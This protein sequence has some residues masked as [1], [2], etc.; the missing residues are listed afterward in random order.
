[1]EEETLYTGFQR[2]IIGFHSYAIYVGKFIFP[3]IMS[4]LYPYPS[5]I[6]PELYVSALLL[7]VSIIGIV[8]AF[9]RGMTQ[10]V[11]GWAFFFVNFIFV[12]QIVGAGQGFLADR[13]TY[14]AYFG[15]FVLLAAFTEGSLFGTKTNENTLIAVKNGENS[16]NPPSSIARIGF[17]IYVVIC[18][19]IT[20]Q[21]TKVWNN[22]ENL[23]TKALEYDDKAT[24]AWMN[25]ALYYR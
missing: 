5:I 7:V 2:I 14:V 9:R 12:S 11:F 1:M 18:L 20:F 17:M 15:F 6:L 25:R 21:Q 10:L 3:W 13:F 24:T 23:W 16:A 4:P 8:W 19:F 22:G